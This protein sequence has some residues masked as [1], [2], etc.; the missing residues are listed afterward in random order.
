MDLSPQPDAS[1]RALFK[2]RLHVVDGCSDLFPCSTPWQTF[3][4]LTGVTVDA[5]NDT[6]SCQLQWCSKGNPTNHHDA[7][8]EEHIVFVGMW[9]A[10]A[11]A[12]LSVVTPHSSH[13]VLSSL[14]ASEGF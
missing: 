13:L 3:C 2:N 5:I 7:K 6:A 4:R 10:G 14:V 1:C 9:L 12:R 11:P 8:D